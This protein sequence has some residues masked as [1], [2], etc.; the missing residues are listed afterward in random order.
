MCSG[1]GVLS[2][3]RIFPRMLLVTAM[4]VT[5]SR[6]VSAAIY[7][8]YVKIGSR[9]FDVKLE[10]STGNGRT[11]WIACAT[12]TDQSGYNRIAV[13]LSDTGGFAIS[14]GRTFRLPEAKV[15]EWRRQL[16]SK[17]LSI[18]DLSRFTVS[19]DRTNALTCESNT[20]IAITDF[21]VGKVKL[22]YEV[23]KIPKDQQTT[24]EYFLKFPQLVRLTS[25]QVYSLEEWY[26]GFSET[27]T[28]SLKRT[29]SSQGGEPW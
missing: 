4:L 5:A 13:Q 23:L 27:V 9:V 11:F 24:T 22:S 2:F 3:K 29:A 7:E 12:G 19:A 15:L 8:G 26:N 18:I 17:F 6:P 28:L 16:E 25:I 21:L 20:P 10:I 1:V 14:E